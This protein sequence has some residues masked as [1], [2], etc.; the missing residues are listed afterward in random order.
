MEGA[1]RFL[2][3]IA[4]DQLRARIAELGAK[5][6]QDYRGKD[7]VLVCV[8]KGA[9]LFLADLVRA[10]DLPLSVEFLAL[11]SYGDNTA[12][13]GVVQITQD[14]TR[15]IVGKDVLVVEDIVDTGLT[16]DFLLGHL[17]VRMPRSVRVCTLLHKPSHTK[18][19]V[20]LDYVGFVI[21]DR[22]V[23]GYGLDYEQ[24]YRNLPY[25]GYLKT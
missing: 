3:L 9:F 16:L 2:P 8:L 14:L 12:S 13:N 6:T 25:V 4:E 15:P 17:R 10:I 21:E 11:S 20:P 22:F 24:K 7:L 1:E 19:H 23:V 18:R 5:V